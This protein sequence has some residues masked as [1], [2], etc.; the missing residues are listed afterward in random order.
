MNR[1][2]ILLL[3]CGVVFIAACEQEEPQ[4]S[5][6]VLLA[7]AKEQIGTKD[8]TPPQTC[9]GEETDEI[10][11]F[12][13]AVEVRRKRPSRMDFYISAAEIKG[14][15][16]CTVRWRVFHNEYDEES[17]EWKRDGQS[18]T[19]VIPRI[20]PGEIATMI[21][22]VREAEFPR[23]AEPGA[24]DAWTIDVERYTAVRKAPF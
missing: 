20:A 24:P 19:D 13:L 2:V 23:V 4:R 3:A 15:E 22:A 8:Q 9:L 16:V 14:L 10:P 18:A 17:K 6:E 7:Q 12:D 21:T 5:D 1:I 11:E